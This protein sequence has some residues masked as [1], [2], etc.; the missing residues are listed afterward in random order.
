MNFELTEAEVV[1][2]T[3]YSRQQLQRHRLGSK[4]VQGGKEYAADPVLEQGKDWKRYGGKVGV[5]GKRKGGAVLYAQHTV[6][7]L[8]ER[9]ELA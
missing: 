4:Q 9:R 6:T 1:R 3:G 5:D 8:Q 2:L 7:I